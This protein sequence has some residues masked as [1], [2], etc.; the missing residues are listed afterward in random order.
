MLFLYHMPIV[1]VARTDKFSRGMLLAQS[2]KYQLGMIKAA[3]E[4]M[5]AGKIRLAAEYLKEWNRERKAYK[6][7][8]S[9][10]SN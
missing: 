6:L 4:S 7:A 2:L 1:I 9:W 3:R 10:Q 5:A 8:L